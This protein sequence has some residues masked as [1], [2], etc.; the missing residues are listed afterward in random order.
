MKPIL[1]FIGFFIPLSLSAQGFIPYSLSVPGTGRP[2]KMIPI[3]GGKFIM[4]SPESE[5]GRKDDEG[6][7]RE[8]TISDLWMGEME[9]T[10]EQYEAFVYQK[11]SEIPTVDNDR[12]SE[13]GIDGITGAT[14]PYVEMSFGMGKEGYPAVNM[15]QYGALMF[16][17][18][19]SALTGDFY[20]LPTE[21]EWEY[22]CKGGEE[23]PYS[24]EGGLG[25]IEEYAVINSDRYAKSGMKKPSIW[26]LF[27][28]NGN[29]AEWTMDQYDPDYYEKGKKAVMD[30]WNFPEKLYPR[31]VRGGS[32]KQGAAE[33]RCSARMPSNENWK[34]RDPQLPKSFWWH[35]NAPFVGF[36][37]VRP[38]ETPSKKEIQKYWLKAIEDF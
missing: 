38:A 4:G 6:P 21:A 29:V 3:Q 22:A 23:R 28:M 7:Q 19:I 18:W 16:C 27:D 5:P 10:W 15:T 25:A 17:K 24:F 2:V 1:I 26:G 20:R 11:L 13:L 32:W 14:S 34:R 8:V 36:R 31:T 33:A 35:T 12:L 9:I 37:I 30:P